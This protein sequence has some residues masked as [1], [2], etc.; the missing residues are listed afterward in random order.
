MLF[1]TIQGWGRTPLAPAG[2]VDGFVAGARRLIDTE[3]PGNI[4]LRLIERGAVRGEIYQSSGKPVDANTLFQV[5]SL[6]KWITAWGVLHLVDEGTLDLDAPVTRYLTRWTIP[7]SE[8]DTGGVT[9][10]RLL[11]HT[12]G[13]TDGLGYGGFAPGE[14]E[15]SL[16]ASLT[17]ASDAMPGAD[18]RVRVGLAPG[19]QWQYSGGGYT[20]LQLVIEETTGTDFASYMKRVVFIPLGMARSTFSTDEALPDAADFYDTDGSIATHFRFTA[21]AAASLYTSVEDLTRFAAAHLHGGEAAGRGV[22][23]PSTLVQMRTPQAYVLSFPIWGLGTILYAPI[24]DS[25]FVIGHDGN[26]AP[27][28]NTAMRLDPSNG[29]AIIVMET[30]SSLLATR[31]ASEWVFWKT[32]TPELHS[33]QMEASGTLR[34]FG[35]GALVILLIAISFSCGRIRVRHGPVI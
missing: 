10:R 7:P 6:S 16:E 22:L 25:D 33:L 11:S 14:P 24:A 12:A 5:A 29:D 30:G 9:I 19:S 34:V 13:L 35:V 17:Q 27:A 18:G 23:N 32:G 2:D 8:F 15:Q 20:L 31:I 3:L 26:N 4:A 21:Q 1:A 28:I